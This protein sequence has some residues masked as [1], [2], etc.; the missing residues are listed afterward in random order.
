MRKTQKIVATALSA[1]VAATMCVAVPATAAFADGAAAGAGATAGATDTET[2]AFDADKMNSATDQFY[3]GK[4]CTPYSGSWNAKGEYGK[5]KEGVDYTV[6]YKNNI[7]KGTATATITGIG[8]YSGVITKTFNIIE[9]SLNISYDGKTIVSMD[10]SAVEA[11]AKSSEDNDKDLYYQYGKDGSYSVCY[12]PAK[13]Y[14]T[15]KSLMQ[16]Q[17]V[18]SWGALEAVAVGGGFSYTMPATVDS[19][20]MFWPGQTKDSVSIVDDAKSAPAILADSYS[21][22]PINTTAAEAAEAAKNAY[23]SAKKTNASKFFV[24]CSEGEYKS[25]Q[26]FGNR[27]V[28]GVAQ[29]NILSKE[30]MKT[31]NPVK[32]AK[33][34][35][36]V[37][38]GKTVAVKVSKA[39]GK[40]SAKSSKKSVAKV[41]YSKKTGKV[42]IKGVKKGKATITVSAAGNKDYKA[43]T[44]TIKVTVK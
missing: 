17:G 24:G 19:E 35:A 30:A 21:E 41:S 9:Y 32:V 4:A 40:V 36:T 6:E 10:K 20:A 28:T 7:E 29:I 15:V 39:Q 13:T 3:T 23:A 33:A 14:V 12:V 1:A 8:K 25:D 43:G 22:A 16:A 18:S 34:K 2:I 26:M 5:L 44:K 27:Y 42:T 11:L 38:K 31:P 37:K